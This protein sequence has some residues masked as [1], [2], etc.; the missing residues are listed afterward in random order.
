MT[1]GAFTARVIQM[2]LG[3]YAAMFFYKHVVTRYRLWLWAR[4][5]R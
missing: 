3:D 5:G 1:A 4:I 2:T